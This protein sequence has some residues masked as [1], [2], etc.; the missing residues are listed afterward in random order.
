MTQPSHP[1]HLTRRHLLLGAASLGAAGRLAACGGGGGD[2]RRCPPVA[3]RRGQLCQRPDHRLRLDHRR[4]CA[5]RRQRARVEG[6]DGQTRRRD[7]LKL[8]VWSRSRA[9][10][11]TARSA[12]CTATRVVLGTRCS[13]RATDAAARG[14]QLGAPRPDRGR[15]RQHD[16]RR[17]RSA[18]ASLDGIAA[19]RRRRGARAVRPRG[20]A[21]HRHP[22]RGQDRRHRVPPARA[23]RRASIPRPGPSCSAPKPSTT[24][25]RVPAVQASALFEG[26]FVRV[27]L[28]TT[29]DPPATP[30]WRRACASACARCNCA[31]TPR[32]RSRA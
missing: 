31:M 21:V 23:R 30:G 24:A 27:H 7:E 18:A 4:R 8:G 26:A 15:H 5:L 13:A 22:A 6:D 12:L 3:G 11:S 32:P 20:R 10:G 2:E 29:K 28:Q 14:Q 17:Q 1:V 9:A 19:G 16:L 25:A